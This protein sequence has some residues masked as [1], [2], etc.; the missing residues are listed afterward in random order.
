MMAAAAF[1]LLLALVGGLVTYKSAGA[2]RHLDRA[3]TSG[4]LLLRSDVVTA[5]SGTALS[6][7]AGSWNYL[8]VVWPA[9]AFGVAIS[10]AVRAFTP[11]IIARSVAESVLKVELRKVS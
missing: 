6:V 3:R 1:V 11:W 4:E 2:L 5:G 8:G 10:T 9:L 7:V